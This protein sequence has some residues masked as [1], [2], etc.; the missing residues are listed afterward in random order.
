MAFNAR[1]FIYD[2]ES[3]ETYGLMIYDLD[4]NSGVKTEDVGAKIE[5]IEDRTARNI[6]PITYGIKQEDPYTFELTFGSLEPIERSYFTEII[7][8]LSGRS[9][10]RYLEII[11]DDMAEIRYKCYMTNI[12]HK[13][14]AGIP[15]AFTAEVICNCPYAYSYPFVYAY[16]ISGSQDI[17][18][19]NDSAT[20]DPIYPM[21]TLIPSNVTQTVSII[22]KSDNN[23]EFQ[24]TGLN[25]YDNETIYIDNKTKVI[26]SDN[27]VNM[28]EYFNMTYF[29]LIRG[30]NEI[31]IYGDGYVKIEFELYRVAG[32]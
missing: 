20:E 22:N 12:Q 6:E 15:Y 5:M 29:R 18:I 1:K 4:S 30:L 19:L 2:G 8:W 24:F 14:I 27:S 26:T 25:N 13:T 16:T 11:E 10:Y 17:S 31:S 3:C 21:I 28:Y 23:R 7:H 32:A 9:Q